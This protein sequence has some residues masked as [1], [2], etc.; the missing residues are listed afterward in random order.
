MAGLG[1]SLQLFGTAQADQ[2]YATPAFNAAPSPIFA[3]TYDKI[4]E[5]PRNDWGVAAGL[6]A[7][8]S[9]GK[10]WGISGGL[11]YAFFSNRIQV[12]QRV[13]QSIVLQNS[14][15][16]DRF[17][18]NSGNQY[19]D[20][21]NRFH[22]IGIPLSADFQVLKKLPLRVSTG[23]T[24][25]RLMKTNV[26]HYDRMSNIFYSEDAQIN[27]TQTMADFGLSYA[28]PMRRFSLSAGPQF[29]YGLASL[30]EGKAE[31]HLFYIG[32]KAQ[33]LFQNKK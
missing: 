5:A 27:K 4:P 10:R 23:V 24:V 15:G 18:T 2:L 19:Y 30:K 11:Q 12:G 21:Q 26:L 9:I 13:L 17:Y 33:I 7:R 16:V 8:R 14:M 29:Q 6:V 20:Y 25:Q 1:Q 32:L 31:P 28:I 22:F 3:G